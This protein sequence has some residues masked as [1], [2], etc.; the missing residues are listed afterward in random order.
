MVLVDTSVWIRFLANR[1]PYS[2]ELDSLLDHNEVAAHDLVYGE[3][4]I[5]DL[6]GRHALLSSYEL[7]YRIPT[8]PHPELVGFVRDHRL[9]GRGLGWVD[10]HLLASA[11]T[12]N[13]AFWTADR[14]LAIVAD[15][16]GIGYVPIA[17]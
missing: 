7:L 4:L 16:L 1:A 12:S 5:G 6:G 3:L 13:T 9:N 11:L 8:L 10:A 15:K 2:A 14:R 17:T